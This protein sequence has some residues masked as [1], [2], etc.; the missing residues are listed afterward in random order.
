[1]VKWDSASPHEQRRNDVGFKGFDTLG[2]QQ[3]LTCWKW[4]YPVI[5]SCPGVPQPGRIPPPSVRPPT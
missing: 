3:C 5:H 2:R 4:Q 1:M